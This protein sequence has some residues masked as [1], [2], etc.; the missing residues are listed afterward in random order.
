MPFEALREGVR[1]WIRL[2]W[3][4]LSSPLN[5]LTILHRMSARGRSFDENDPNDKLN[6]YLFK[7]EK[8]K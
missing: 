5:K 1:I 2:L 6:V 7:Q 8:I 3:A 4:A